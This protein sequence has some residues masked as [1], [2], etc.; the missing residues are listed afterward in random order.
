[1][2]II[3]EGETPARKQGPGAYP[4]GTHGYLTKKCPTVRQGKFTL[5]G[6]ECVKNQYKD[7]PGK[8]WQAK[9]VSETNLPLFQ[10]QYLVPP[11]T[12]THVAVLPDK[13]LLM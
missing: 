9:T 4:Q 7:I 10:D 2:S 6:E 11:V 3:Y 8:V 1:M 13:G 5:Y 12:T